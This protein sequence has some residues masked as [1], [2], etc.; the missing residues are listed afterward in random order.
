M[1]YQDGWAALNLEMPSKVPRT[2]YS[3]ETHWDLIKKVTG[4]DAAAAS[5]EERARASSA[6]VKAWDYGFYWNVLINSQVFGDKRSKMGHASYAAGGE[7]YD[8]ETSQLYEDPEDAL[9]FDPYEMY[10]AVDQKELVKQFDKD[11]LDKRQEHPD[12]LNMTGIYI[13]CMSGLIDIF[14]WDTLLEMAGISPKGFGELADRYAEW[15]LQFFVALA[16]SSSPVVMIHDDI[17]WSQ[18]PFLNPDWYRSRIFPNYK[19]C[20]APLIEAGKKIIY[21]CDGDYTLFIDDIAECGINAFVLEPYTDMAQIAERRGKTHAF[22]GNADTRV[23][24]SG[25]KEDIYAEV[26]RCMDIGKKCPGFFMAVGNHIPS[27]TPVDNA[28]YYN[29][30]YEKM[31]RR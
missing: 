5:K 4:I 18:G 16:R 23:L 14:G 2:E 15:I 25:S 24:L 7:D 27:N 13:T 30:A 9:S 19:K 17:V 1:S 31:S 22:V 6:F 3:A 12:T 11:F 29:E 20:F 8:N 28:L 21:T 10:G 26:K